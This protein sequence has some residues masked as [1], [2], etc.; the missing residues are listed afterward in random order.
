MNQCSGRTANCTMVAIGPPDE[1]EGTKEPRRR[2]LHYDPG[3]KPDLRYADQIFRHMSGL[4][5]T[6]VVLSCDAEQH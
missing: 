5:R 3:S 4:I 2:R 6:A 1:T